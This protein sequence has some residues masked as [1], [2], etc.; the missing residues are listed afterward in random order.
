MSCEGFV[1]YSSFGFCQAWGSGQKFSPLP[2][3]EIFAMT[4]G[5]LPRHPNGWNTGPT[6]RE[7]IKINASF[8]L[9]K[10]R[11]I[12]APLS[13]KTRRVARIY[14]WRMIRTLLFAYWWMDDHTDRWVHWVPQSFTCSLHMYSYIEITCIPR[15]KTLLH[16]HIFPIWEENPKIL[17]P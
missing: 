16:V 7:P 3:D 6:N 4:D 15:L 12:D 9:L 1:V 5:S 14:A 13:L 11:Q 17:K 2:S 8:D 10:S